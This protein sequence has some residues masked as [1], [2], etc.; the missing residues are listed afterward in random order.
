MSEYAEVM[1]VDNAQM[2]FYGRLAD[3][4]KEAYQGSL[5]REQSQIKC[6]ISTVVQQFHVSQGTNFTK[7][8]DFYVKH[9]HIY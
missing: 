9:P 8:Y 3:L 6:L 5:I 1:R 4:K 2:P 7:M